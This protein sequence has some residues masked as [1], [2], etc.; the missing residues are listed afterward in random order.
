MPTT[1]LVAA[2]LAASFAAVLVPACAVEA[3]APDELGTRTDAIIAGTPATVGQFPQV[4]AILNSGLC[5]GTLVAPDLVLTAAHCVHPSTLGLG[6]QAQ[7]TAQTRVVLD[8]VDVTRGGGRQI[9]AA[10]T[11]AI[12]TFGQPGDA[13][14][15]LIWLSEDVTD[16]EPALIHPGG[17][18]LAG[19]AVDLVGFGETES[20]SYGRLLYALDKPQTG[21]GQYGVDGGDFICLDQRSGSG[22]CSGDSGGP[23]LVEIDGV[24]RVVGITS[25]G[26]QSCTQLGAHYRTDAEGSR[27]F[28]QTNAPE[29]L[30][31]ADGVCDSLCSADPDCRASCASDDACGDDEYC[32]AD[33]TCA[34][35]PFTGG[36]VGSECTGN[37]DC[38]SDLCAAAGD[39]QRCVDPCT[40]GEG[41][42]PDGFACLAAGSGG[43]VCWPSEG[44]GDGGGEEGVCSSG[45]GRGA[46]GTLALVLGATLVA[47]RRRRRA[48]RA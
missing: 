8:S 16:R 5:T 39:E 20:G 33:G 38:E 18:G 31:A 15:G 27:A 28:L 45:G 30:C 26:D 6:S 37:A 47:A 41:G 36:G 44:D 10:D 21:C 25:F 46:A 32:A 19:A 17:P 24:Q 3:P 48:P 2:S 23:A 13:D 29:L 9:A 4:V 14:I 40:V 43:G 12:G 1:R 7:V 11:R 35:A 34:P 42:C 22:I